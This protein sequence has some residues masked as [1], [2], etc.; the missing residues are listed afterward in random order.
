M[1]ETTYIKILKKKELKIAYILTFFPTHLAKMRIIVAK[2]GCS[3][4]PS[5]NF[6]SLKMLAA[7][8]IPDKSCSVSFEIL[9]VNIAVDVDYLFDLNQKKSTICSDKVYVGK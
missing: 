6:I 4:H 3:Y 8:E 1:V 5:Y 2:N 9:C 7:S